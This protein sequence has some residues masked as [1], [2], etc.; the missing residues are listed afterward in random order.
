MCRNDFLWASFRSTKS[1][2]KIHVKYD[3]GGAVPEYLFVTNADMHENG[4][5]GG[6]R[7]KEGDVVTFDKGYNNYRQFSEFCDKG[8]HFVTRLKDNADYKVVRRL[9]THCA[10]ITSDWIISFTGAVDSRN[11]SVQS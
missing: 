6:M 10:G 2:V 5:L 1:G 11:P 3:V 8:V 9:R 4:T 7:L